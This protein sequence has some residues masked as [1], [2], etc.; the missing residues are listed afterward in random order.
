MLKAF[1]S[2]LTYDLIKLDRSSL[3]L[4]ALNFF[5]YDTIKIFLLLAVII[6]IVSISRCYFP[7]ER[8]KRIFSHKRKFIGNILAA[9][10]GTVTLFCSCSDAC[11]R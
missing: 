1:A 8:T 2:Y 7:P 10:S 6:F 3:L 4:D 11:R 9:L 5:I